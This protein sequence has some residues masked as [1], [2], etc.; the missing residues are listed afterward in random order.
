MK[1]LYE[2]V[3]ITKQAHWKARQKQQRDLENETMVLADVRVLRGLHPR[4][5]GKNLYRILRPDS[6]G[7]DRFLDLLAEEGLQLARRR[8]SSRTTWS[9]KSWRYA[10]LLEGIVLTGVDQVWVTDITYFFIGPD[11]YYIV[12]IMDLYS[13][14]ILG[15]SVETHMRAESCLAALAMAF[16]TRGRSQFGQ[17][18][19]HHSDRGSQYASDLYT[20]MLEKSGIRISMCLVVYEN[21]HAE[22]LNGTIKNDYLEPKKPENLGDLKRMLRET[23]RLYDEERPHESL[24]RITP[25]QFEE[26]IKGQPREKLLEM[27]PFVHPDTKVRNRLR[28]QLTIFD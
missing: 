11:C 28:N 10:N 7:R 22:R 3:G 2:S 20:G 18:L 21:S 19:I 26:S 27:R 25:M 16:K 23:V 24:G 6:M 5:G 4:M 8:N 1:E 13:R 14:R 9:V 12:L 15:F 17:T